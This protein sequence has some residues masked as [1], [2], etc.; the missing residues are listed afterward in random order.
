MA[1]P[2]KPLAAFA[3]LREFKAISQESPTLA[4][5][6]AGELARALRREIAR[7]GDATAVVPGW[8]GAAALVWVQAGP[9]SEADRSELRAANAGKV[10]IV[11]VVVGSSAETPGAPGAA[12]TAAQRLPYVLAT[13]HVPVGP[14]V[15]FPV[16]EIARALGRRVGER[17]SGLAARLPELRE[18]ICDSLVQNTAK[19]NAM[20]GS[21]IPVP[22]ADLPLL[23]LT[24]IRLALRIA[25]AHG[26][27]VDTK[28][29]P[30]LLGVVVGGVGLRSIARQLAGSLGPGWLVKG[31][32]AYG[33]TRAIGEAAIRYF[34]HRA[35]AVAAPAPAPPSAE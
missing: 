4:V 28:R 12:T 31:A 24:Q 15:A 11:A 32:I 21:A 7:G 6:G 5:A 2:L 25:H 23:A 22:G 13:A 35:P 30:E 18:G 1:L 29:L 19:R 16:G 17:S 10:P 3:L 33:G 14:G 34:E 27:P 9:L 8:K 26:E 20:I